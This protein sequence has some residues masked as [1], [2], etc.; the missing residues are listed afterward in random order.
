[1]ELIAYYHVYTNSYWKDHATKKL[2]ALQSCKLLENLSQLNI[3]VTYPEPENI[4]FLQN[5]FNFPIVNIIPLKENYVE[6]EATKLI[7]NISKN[8]DAYH[9]FFHTK[10]VSRGYIQ[11]TVDWDECM[12]YWVIEKWQDC[13]QRLKD[14]DSVGIFNMMYRYAESYYGGNFYWTKSEYVR[15]LENPIKTGFRWY[16]ELWIAK[17]IYPQIHK[18]FSPFEIISI[19]NNF[20]QTYHGGYD[21]PLPRNLYENLPFDI[22]YCE[23]RPE[24]IIAKTQPTIIHQRQPQIIPPQNIPK[25]PSHIIPQ[26]PKQNYGESNIIELEKYLELI[27]KPVN[28]KTNVVETQKYLDLINKPVANKINPNKKYKIL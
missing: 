7:Y 1:M 25:R 12:Q 21:S 14:Y 2:K 22:N 16:Y 19:P 3:T 27:N 28:N 15:C 13:I 18:P 6:Y 20:W 9:L 23:I 17:P 8:K 11:P 24:I 26:R 5:L 4:E 10:G